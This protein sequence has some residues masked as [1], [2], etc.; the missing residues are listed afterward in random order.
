MH[1]S[2]LSESQGTK[3]ELE[4]DLL[5]EDL[6]LILINT[7]FN[8]GSLFQTMAVAVPNEWPH[9]CHIPAMEKQRDRLESKVLCL[10]DHIV[11]LRFVM[12]LNQFGYTV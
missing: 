5:L 8:T 6:E 3:G 2:L 1:F 10:P 12:A 7:H 11:N 4:P 9:Y